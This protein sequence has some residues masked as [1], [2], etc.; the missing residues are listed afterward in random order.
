MRWIKVILL[1]L[2]VAFSSQSKAA[3]P[4][5]FLDP[6]NDVAWPC[7]F[8]IAVMSIPFAVNADY[9][10]DSDYGN[11]TCA[12]PGRYGPADPG[13]GVTVSFWEPSHIVE[14]VKD[15]YC[16]PTLGMRL[17]GMEAIGGNGTHG[18]DTAG[19]RNMLHASFHYYI[20]AVMQLL[21]VM[22]DFACASYDANPFDVAM[23][24]EFRADWN[25]DIV[26][27]QYYP[28]TALMD[29]PATVF[30]CVT[31]AVAGAAN[32]TIDALYWC[33]GAWGTTY[34]MAGVGESASYTEGNALLAAKAL[35][36]QAR[37][38]A[39]EDRAADICYLTNPLIWTK[40]HYRLQQA[41]PVAEHSCH[42]I[43]HTGLLWDHLRDTYYRGDNFSWIVWRKVKCCLVFL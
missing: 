11:P 41:D 14:T 10:P 35:Y 27:M 28:E 29:N 19:S 13:L 8:P 2:A 22:Q 30:A 39:L 37:T 6:V 12:C 20:F 1:L 33:A 31:D 24:S 26:A 21:G 5:G 4:I 38:M 36:V 15:S 3:C 18:R 9:P 25:N 7:I 23:I 43:G 42:A 34:P 17:G 16:F 40:S 32:R